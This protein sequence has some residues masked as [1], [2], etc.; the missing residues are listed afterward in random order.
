M[1]ATESK[2]TDASHLCIIL[3]HVIRVCVCCRLV[4]KSLFS[5]LPKG[6]YVE[7]VTPRVTLYYMYLGHVNVKLH[8]KKNKSKCPDQCNKSREEWNLICIENWNLFGIFGGLH[9]P[10][11]PRVRKRGDLPCSESRRY[12]SFEF[13]EQER[14][15]RVKSYRMRGSPV[16]LN[17][18][19]EDAKR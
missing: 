7:R 8:F 16:I 17:G 2:I 14:V 3:P 19:T 13:G 4:R 10:P 11:V 15:E 12:F 1:Y 6:T 5:S 9:R 18:E